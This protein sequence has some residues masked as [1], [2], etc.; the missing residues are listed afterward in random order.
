VHRGNCSFT[1]KANIAEAASAIAILII[2]NRTGICINVIYH[3][4]DNDFFKLVVHLNNLV[5][6]NDLCLIYYLFG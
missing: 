6:S 5:Q 2:N 1:K 4:C 3:V